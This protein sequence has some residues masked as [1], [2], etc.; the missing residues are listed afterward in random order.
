MKIVHI[1]DSLSTGGKERRLIELIR[2]FYNFHKDVET[3]LIILSDSVDFNAIHDLDVNVCICDRNK[4]SEINVFFKILKELKRSRPDI[5]HSWIDVGSIHAS[6]ARLFV[7]TKFVNGIIASTPD[8]KMFSKQWLYS[9][10]SFLFSD[11]ILGNSYAG[12][13]AY[14][15]PEKKSVCVHNGFNFDRL[16]GLEDPDSVR[17]RLNIRTKHVA[18]MAAS[19][20]VYKDYAT[21]VRCANHVL[22]KFSDIT[23]LSIGRGDKIKY[24]DMVEEKNRDRILFLDN[25]K[26]IESIMNICDI[27]VLSTY[28]EGISN[29]I[30][31]FMALGKPVVATGKGG[32]K[33]II[34]DG[35]TGYILPQGDHIQ[36]AEMI[37]KLIN[38]PSLREE[39][40][41]GSLKT[42][43]EEFS[44]E[45]MCDNMY[46]LYD[47]LL[48]GKK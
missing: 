18:A 23:F 4:Y 33:E 31:E 32:T 2:Y 14:G 41:K 1:I 17:K 13:Q 36:M 46:V 29:S 10:S 7:K 38:D 35:V 20:T 16:K 44:I 8:L 42:I 47:E 43:K 48:K 39:M 5:I 40:G 45:R 30:M 6:A 3:S 12:I 34:K 15:A 9:K 24:I 27:G 11:V 22:E 26:E 19:F 25:Q 37:L 21:Y 28:S